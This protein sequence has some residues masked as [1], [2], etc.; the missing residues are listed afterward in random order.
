MREESQMMQSEM[1]EESQMMQSEMMQ[2]EMH[3][4]A[5]PIF[6]CAA[7]RL[8]SNVDREIGKSRHAVGVEATTTVA[9]ARLVLA[10][11]LTIENNSQIFMIAH[12]C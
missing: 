7:P 8:L 3:E 11:A 12:V 1:R 6:K 4:E 10:L 5:S 9:D 2:S